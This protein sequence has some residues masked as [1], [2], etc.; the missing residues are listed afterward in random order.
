MDKPLLQ[1]DNLQ[2]EDFKE[3]ESVWNLLQE[4][5]EKDLYRSFYESKKNI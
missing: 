5:N 3:N 1:E 4:N 2:T